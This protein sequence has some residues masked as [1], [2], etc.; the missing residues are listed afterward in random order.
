MHLCKPSDDGQR[1][2]YAS[3]RNLA[4]YFGVATNTILRVLSVLRETGFFV[5][6]GTGAWGEDRNGKRVYKPIRTADNQYLSND[7][8][9]LSHSQFEAKHPD[10][11]FKP[12]APSKPHKV[13]AK[14]VS[15]A[16]ETGQGA[17][18]TV[19]ETGLS[20]PMRDRAVSTASETG[21]SQPTETGLSQQLVRHNLREQ[22]PK[23]VPIEVTREDVAPETGAQISD[24]SSLYSHTNP[25]ATAAI[26][27]DHPV[28]ERGVRLAA[29]AV[30]TAVGTN[31]NAVIYNGNRKTL[32]RLLDGSDFTEDEIRRFTK[33]RIDS[34]DSF[35]LKNAGGVLC[36][37]LTVQIEERRE[38]LAEQRREQEVM[39]RQRA[40]M[41]REA[42]E[43][44]AAAE[45]PD[46]PALIEWELP[47]EPIEPAAVAEGVAS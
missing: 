38:A 17:V 4:D 19:I 18:S 30:K 41:Q 11:C 16:S 12:E 35:G 46:D 37:T 5:P 15:T 34:L 3:V 40:E 23:A 7:Y 25:A 9:V 47:Q 6:L 14:A 42:A 33:D 36:A 45:E 2:F 27:Q 20:Q 31:A 22:S 10:L 1:R 43:M 39:A 13:G 29:L 24:P 28:S 21:L 8:V 44:A 26:G 32:E